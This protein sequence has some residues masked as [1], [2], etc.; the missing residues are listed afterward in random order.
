MDF[1]YVSGGWSFMSGDFIVIS[2]ISQK[3]YIFHK[4]GIGEICL[5]NA[6]ST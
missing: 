4:N 6:C 1:F 5:R 3:L 2:G